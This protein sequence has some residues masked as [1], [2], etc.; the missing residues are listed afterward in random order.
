[1]RCIVELAYTER[2]NEDNLGLLNL[3]KNSGGKLR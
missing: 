3:T 1:M 2:N